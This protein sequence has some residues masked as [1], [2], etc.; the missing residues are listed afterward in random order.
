M[1]TPL[2]D[3]IVLAGGFGTR[4]KDTVPGLPK[5]M[6]PVGGKPFLEYLMKY[7]RNNFVEK[8]VFSLGYLPE[9]FKEY[10]GEQY[11]NISLSY[12]IED[13]PLGTGGALKKAFQHIRSG[14]VIVMN[15][16]TLFDVDLHE[17]MQQHQQSGADITIALHHTQDAGRYGTVNLNRDGRIVSFSEKTPG[18]GQGWI[19]GGVYIIRQNYFDT[20]PLPVKFSLEHDVFERYVDTAKMYGYTSNGYFIDIGIPAD[21]HRACEELPDIIRL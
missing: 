5:C 3:A 8:V 10:F 4:L 17:M 16:D 14:N 21:Y 13:E 2:P 11:H 19:N 15:G 9:A 6:S 7:L 18:Q 12:S 20:L 1:M